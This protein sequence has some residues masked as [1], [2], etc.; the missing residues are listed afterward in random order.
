MNKDIFVN[1]II[2][3]Y[4]IKNANLSKY[5]FVSK[6]GFL[7][8]IKTKYPPMYDF[9][10][11]VVQKNYLGANEDKALKE[12]GNKG[13]VNY[14]VMM[15][16]INKAIS[17]YVAFSPTDAGLKAVKETANEVGSGLVTASRFLIFGMLGVA[18]FFAYT[19]IKGIKK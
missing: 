8:Y 10:A 1:K 17:K 18:A 4:W 11:E 2:D 3:G 12:A 7:N 19:Y 5:Q 16:D 13:S 9:F 15:N 14:Q 6:A